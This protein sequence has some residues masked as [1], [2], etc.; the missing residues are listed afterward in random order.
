MATPYLVD[1]PMRFSYELVTNQNLERFQHEFKSLSEAEADP[2]GYWLKMKKAKGETKDSDEV[3]LELLVEL[4]RK[5]DKLEKLIKG[6]EEKLLDL[7]I[8]GLIE[9]I[10]FTQFQLQNGDLT[11]KALYYGRAELKVYPQREIPIFFKAITNNLAE[12][13]KIHH[14]DEQ[15][16]GSYFRARERVM[17]RERRK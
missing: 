2:I 3:V 1:A 4:N 16:W 13:E 12:I 17:I 7:E 9:K 8:N 11:P 6:E 15:D 14:R 10:N 5:I